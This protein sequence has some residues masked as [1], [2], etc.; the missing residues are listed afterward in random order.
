MK[1]KKLKIKIKQFSLPALVLLLIII[2]IKSVLVQQNSEIQNANNSVPTTAIIFNENTNENQNILCTGKQL[3]G[4]KVVYVVDG[5]TIDISTGERVR[6]VGV[7]TPETKHPIKGVECFGREA[8]EKNKELILG[9]EVRLEKDI[10]DKDKYGRLLRYVYLDNLFINDYLARNG[11]AHAATFP[12][13]VK[14]SKIF[15]AA[16]REARE[17]LRGLWAPGRCD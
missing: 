15:L 8:A 9:K 17:N 5:D 10:S 14:F 3:C 2:L 7:D 11:F 16:E 1:K 6:Y 12:P 13:D 4:A